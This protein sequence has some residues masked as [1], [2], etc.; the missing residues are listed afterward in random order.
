M[1][2]VFNW[3][4][5]GGGN[6]VMKKL[7]VMFILAAG[8][9]LSAMADDFSGY[10]VDQA[11]S[12]KKA[13]WED[14]ACVTRCIKRGSP[15]VLVSEEGKVYKIANQDKIKEETYGKKVTVTGK[16]DGDTIT[17]DSVTM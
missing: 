17:V 12:G 4:F 9:S 11:C 6:F 15:A 7:S 13:M 16:M 5:R 2:W 10:I 3:V 8:L 14:T 1:N